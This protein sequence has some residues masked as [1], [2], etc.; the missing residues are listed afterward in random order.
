VS[1]LARD[2]GCSPLDVLCELSVAEDLQTR[3]RAYIANDDV[4]EVGQLLTHDHVVL[5]LSDAGAHVDQLCDAPLPTDLLG[6]W[7]RE[8]RVL[9]LEHAV[10]KL[11]GEPADVFGFARRGY[12][13]EGYW[14]DLCVFEPDAVAPGPT[15]RVHDF[16]AG[17][18][19]LTAE[20][21]AGVR[22]VLV[23]G[24]PI[25]RD[26]AQA[27]TDETRPGTRPEIA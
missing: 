27:V 22:H 20:E 5:G 23:N 1:D 21:P 2:R 19:R 8:R 4:E 18:E 13:R 14:A 6:R 3:F 25:R 12:I 17:G 10:R 11:T 24:T 7:V 16:P 26:G 9:T 15:W